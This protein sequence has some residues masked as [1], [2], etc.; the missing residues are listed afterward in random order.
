MQVAA[1]IKAIGRDFEKPTVKQQLAAIRMLFDCLV[2]ARS[3][4]SIPRK[5]YAAPSTHSQQLANGFCPGWSGLQI[6]PQQ[7]HFFD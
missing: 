3:S 5:P 1:Y 6:C 7:V 4:P 2:T